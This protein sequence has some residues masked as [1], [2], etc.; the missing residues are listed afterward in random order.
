M[1]GPSP[2][3]DE[4]GLENALAHV[5]GISG[6]WLWSDAIPEHITMMEVQE[7][8]HNSDLQRFGLNDGH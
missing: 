8:F 1:L 4:D 3:P 2:V 6:E 5:I 7:R